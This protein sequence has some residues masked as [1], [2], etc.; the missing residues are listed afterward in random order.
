MDALSAEE[1]NRFLSLLETN[2]D[3]KKLFIDY[4]KDISDPKVRKQQEDLLNNMESLSASQAPP[5]VK[6]ELPFSF[7]YISPLEFSNHLLTSD[8]P[9]IQYKGISLRLEYPTSKSA[10]AALNAISVVFDDVNPHQIVVSCSKYSTSVLLP[11][12][13]K[14]SSPSISLHSKLKNIV[15]IDFGIDLS[16]E[17]HKPNK[18]TV[19]EID[20]DEEVER[21]NGETSPLEEEVSSVEAPQNFTATEDNFSLE[22]QSKV[23]EE[24]LLR[25]SLFSYFWMDSSSHCL[26]YFNIDAD[27]EVKVS[28]QSRSLIIKTS[29]SGAIVHFP[30]AISVDLSS[31]KKSFEFNELCIIKVKKIKSQPWSSCLLSNGI[32]N[33]GSKNPNLSEKVSSMTIDD[34]ALLLGD[35]SNCWKVF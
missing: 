24:D 25:L 23:V 17:Q 13:V 11:V 31:W 2:D 29:T 34:V 7:V 12:Q 19:V 32:F 5:V 35:F 4:A 18:P 14:Q 16:H 33:N 28:F 9:H 20:S 21:T 1:Q 8:L 27:H 30:E 3:F 15:R 22:Q 26:L 6:S 10:M